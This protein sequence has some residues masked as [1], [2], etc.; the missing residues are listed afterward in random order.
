MSSTY[1]A[2]CL[3]HDPALIPGTELSYSEANSLADRSLLHDHQNCDIAVG[4]W[5]G[6]LVEV[7]CLGAQLPGPTGCK[8]HHGRAEWTDKKWLWLLA[9]AA[10]HITPGLL[11]PFTDQGCWPL[12]RLT[13]LRE[14]LGLPTP[15]TTTKEL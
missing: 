9:A 11:A 5:S 6:A 12:G 3:S 13:R 10:P 7:G 15:T 8:A 14:E 4:R 2:I 1:Y